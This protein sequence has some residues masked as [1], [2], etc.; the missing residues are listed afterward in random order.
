MPHVIVKLWP[1]R[2]EEQKKILTEK[3]TD[4]LKETMDASDSSISVAIE[5]I[6]RHEWKHKVYDPEIIARKDILYRQPD[7]EMK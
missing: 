1:G 3:I 7:Y 4:A 5:E 6:P 2:S